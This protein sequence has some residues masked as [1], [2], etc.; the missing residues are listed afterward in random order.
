MKLLTFSKLL[1]H[2]RAFKQQGYSLKEIRLIL[3]GMTWAAS[4]SYTTDF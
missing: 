3:Y 2:A 1:M 4:E